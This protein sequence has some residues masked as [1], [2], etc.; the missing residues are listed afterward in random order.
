MAAQGQ[1]D[2]KLADVLVD[3]VTWRCATRTRRQEWLT[4]IADLVEEAQLRAVASPLRAFVTVEADGIR[5]LFHDPHGAEVGRMELPRATIAPLFREYFTLLSALANQGSGGYSPQVEA[6]DIARRLIHNDAADLLIA[7]AEA[8]I[9]THQT[10]RRL[11]T[12]LTLL[13]HDTSKLHLQ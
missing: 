13:T 10:A 4:A 8:V 11:F 12:L 9:P 2:G 5:V 6:L 3:D 7:H 1:A